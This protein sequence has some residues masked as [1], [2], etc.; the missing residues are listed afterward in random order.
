MKQPGDAGPAEQPSRAGNPSDR[1]LLQQY[2]EGSQDAA[3]EIYGRYARRLHGLVKSQCS[4]ALARRVEVEDIVQSVFGSFFRKA[5]RGY[6]EIPAGEEL[7]KLFLVI[8]LNKVRAK[9][10]FHRAAK[11]DVRVSRGGN[12]LDELADATLK[13]AEAESFLRVVIHDAL[14]QLPPQSKEI[15]VLRIEGFEIAEIA[16]KTGRAKRTVERILQA[17][18]VQLA[19]LFQEAD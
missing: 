15:I 7:W 14:G 5:S 8:A 12:A 6:Y 1:S 9:G 2:Q 11:R 3:A 16:R 18:R 4:A 10:A 13:E 19:S 17:A